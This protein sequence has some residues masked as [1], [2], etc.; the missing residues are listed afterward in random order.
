MKSTRN[1]IKRFGV[2]LAAGILLISCLLA[3]QPGIVRGQNNNTFTLSNPD[4]SQFPQITAF[5][6]PV[7]AAGE[8]IQ[9]LQPSDV[10]ILE[11]SRSVTPSSM[12]KIEPGIHF[13]VAVNEGPT[14]ANR[15][16]GV[17]RFESIKNALSAWISAQP[18]TSVD[19]FS[20]VNNAGTVQSNL[21]N[22][23]DWLKGLQD[24]QPDL[25]AALPAMTSLTSG[26]D[27]AGNTGDNTTKT[28]ALLYITP[29]PE[30]AMLSGIQDAAARAKGLDVRLFIWLIGPQNYSA[31]NA[32]L[33]LQ[34]AASDTGGRFFLFSGAET[35]PDIAGYLN[36]LKFVYQIS[37]LTSI[38]SSGNFDLS[39][40]VKQGST[41]L[42][43]DKVPFSLDVLP[44]NP[45]FLSPP[46]DLS[47]KWVADEQTEELS[48]TPINTQLKILIEFPDGHP[49]ALAASRLFIDGKLE[50]ENTAAPFDIFS[51]DISGY[52]T[53]KTHLLKVY[54]EDQ[55]GLTNQTIE[56]P[57]NIVVE[58]RPQ[59]TVQKVI[60]WFNPLRAVLV[61]LA[62]VGLLIIGWNLIKRS[63]IP[64]L[65]SKKIQR[66]TTDPVTQ[67]VIVDQVR[68]TPA[69]VK[70]EL[71]DWPRVQGGGAAPARLRLCSMDDL[72]PL[73]GEGFPLVKNETTLGSNP[74]K[75][76]IP[77]DGD[78][79][80]E[81]HALILKEAE[82]KYRLQ[83]AGSNTGTWV[84]YTPVS[85]KPINPVNGPG[86]A[87]ETA[88]VILQHGDLIHIGRVPM[89]F[90]LYRAVPRKIQVIPFEEQK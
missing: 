17:V 61:G 34:K 71:P 14:L 52:T 2:W 11:N 76:D 75:V 62:G 8:F 55:I 7:N 85:G 25:R 66:K 59:T 38:R 74:R 81:V 4:T 72:Q 33:V 39:L 78:S 32:A 40:Q 43:S 57:V 42:D 37:Y 89:R 68:I 70:I 63:R 41:T 54:V 28:K 44:P 30:D 22:P 5:F 79:V 58:P 19:D 64:A 45:I 26:I 83:D 29:L 67:P 12:Q 51:W 36:P 65:L 88:G 10:T 16:A 82:G 69:P 56:I 49:R 21:T 46:V 20:I 80:S 31:T 35:L 6:W 53:S 84:N 24:Y 48:L 23:A 1:F 60:A 90:E 86:V 73:P 27:L 15:Y 87:G 47:R 18:S 50:S 3:L 9:D 77:L 13:V